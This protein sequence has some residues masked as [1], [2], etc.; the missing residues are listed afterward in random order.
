MPQLL[1]NAFPSFLEMGQT[2]SESQ[3]L[4]AESNIKQKDLNLKSKRN[5]MYS[6][7]RNFIYRVHKDHRNPGNIS[8]LWAKN[9]GPVILVLSEKLRQNHAQSV[10]FF[11]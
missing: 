1:P 2:L 6:D 9:R 8:K 7:K 5:Y 10:F 3:A 4:V 11:F